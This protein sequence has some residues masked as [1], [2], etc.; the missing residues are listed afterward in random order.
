MKYKHLF[1]PVV[2]RRL[3]LSLGVDVVPYKYCSLN[4]V[5]CEVSRTTHLTLKRKPFFEVEEITSELNDF[6]QSKPELDFITFSGAGEPTL[7]SLLGELIYAIKQR[8]PQYK[9]ALIT[10]STLLNEPDLRR[11]ILPCDLL[12][13]SLDAASQEVFEQINRP[14]D[15]LTAASIIEGL[16]DTRKEYPGQMW[17]EIFIVP[18][19]NDNLEELELLKDAVQR[20]KPDKVQLNSLD[21]APA[22]DW[23]QPALFLSLEEMRAFLQEDN[24]IPIEII[25]KPHQQNLITPAERETLDELINLLKKDEYTKQELASE[26][27]IHV[28][29]VSKLLQYLAAEEQIFSRQTPK[30]IFYAWKM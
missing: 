30:G 7:Y 28:N 23:V 3:G 5:Y 15:K 13:P 27:Q 21:R 18:G 4:C 8:Y 12:L 1:G 17:L 11:E 16:V 22:E 9:L 6:L 20:I 25:A 26:L 2:S 29:E 10:N 14:C 19:L 24:P